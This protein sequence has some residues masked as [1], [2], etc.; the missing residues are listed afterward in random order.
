MPHINI[1]CFPKHLS[2]QEL[3]N[4][5]EELSQVVMKHL[6]ASDKS[7]SISYQEIAQEQWKSD[8]YDKE[9]KPNLDTLA[10]KPGYEM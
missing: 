4:F 1:K 9:I 5:T 7:I 3:K 6:N 10:K 8:V 2:D